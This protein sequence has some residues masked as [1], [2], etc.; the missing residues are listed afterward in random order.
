MKALGCFFCPSIIT[1]RSKE[2]DEDKK[3]TLDKE[4]RGGDVSV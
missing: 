1:L 3:S 2:T 4:E